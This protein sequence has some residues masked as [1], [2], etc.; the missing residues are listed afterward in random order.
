M[1]LTSIGFPLM[2]ELD[3]LD[4]PLVSNWPVSCK[5]PRMQL[6][7]IGATSRLDAEVACTNV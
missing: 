3:T 1:G 2:L 6:I 4:L 5:D 7:L